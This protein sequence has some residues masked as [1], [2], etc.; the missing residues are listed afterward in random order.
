MM[1]PIV[2]KADNPAIF[3]SFTELI[4]RCSDVQRKHV[5]VGTCLTVHFKGIFRK[6][7]FDK[8][9]SYSV[10]GKFL[11]FIPIWPRSHLVGIADRTGWGESAQELQQF[12]NPEKGVEKY[13]EYFW[14]CKVFSTGQSDHSSVLFWQIETCK[15]RRDVGMSEKLQNEV[16]VCSFL[17]C[18]LDYIES[19]TRKWDRMVILASHPDGRP[20]TG[21]V[22]YSRMICFVQEIAR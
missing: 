10:Q 8:S 6:D 18:C 17:Q 20:P 3:R 16:A 1:L 2:V 5:C 13:V 4:H 14:T 21:G 19:K 11:P 9:H 7:M 15:G 12:R 22:D